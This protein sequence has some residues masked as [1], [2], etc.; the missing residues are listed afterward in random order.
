MLTCWVSNKALPPFTPVSEP[1]LSQEGGQWGG[2]IYRLLWC[3]HPENRQRGGGGIQD[4]LLT[5]SRCQTSFFFFFWLWEKQGR[6]HVNHRDAPNIL[7]PHC[8][9]AL[10]TLSAFL[11][12]K[13]PVLGEGPI[14]LWLPPCLLLFYFEG[15]I[16]G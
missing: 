16:K 8:S 7:Q 11:L 10:K 9:S 5:A 15:A 13:H 3:L 1:S 4:C 6:R 2:V 14:Y 12:F